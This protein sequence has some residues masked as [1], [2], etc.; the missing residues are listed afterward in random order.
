MN[1]NT[2]ENNTV[3]PP[4]PDDLFSAD[5]EFAP[6]PPPPA[7]MMQKKE[8]V[9]VPPPVIAAEAP[10]PLSA[11]TP[12]PASAP[13]PKPAVNRNTVPAAGGNFHRN[14][15]VLKA[16]QFAHDAKYGD[17]LRAAREHLK[18]T[19]EDVAQHT[20]LRAYYI[21][22]MEDSLAD[23]L[24]PA[25]YV[26]SYIQTLSVYYALDEK[27][28]ALI[29]ERFD[30]QHEESASDIPTALLET[31]EKD[32]KVN[33]AEDRRVQKVFRIAICSITVLILLVIWAIF[34]IV[35]MSGTPSTP[36]ADPGALEPPSAQPVFTQEEFDSLTTP[37]MPD[38]TILEMNSK[39]RAVRN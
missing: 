7:A 2:P 24:P 17:M 5:T 4:E 14:G 20:R 15:L 33:E 1:D 16:D 28:K 39:P 31:L 38:T 22:A 11:S 37:Q 29:R 36:A 27:S 18:L 12:V 25:V 6:P 30:K 19:V 13:A 32:V 8:A 34:A 35:K 9:A 10:K 23:R 26:R 21:Y 3:P